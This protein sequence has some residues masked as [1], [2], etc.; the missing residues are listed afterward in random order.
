MIDSARY[1]GIVSAAELSIGL[2]CLA[3]STYKPL[4]K[5]RSRRR[6]TIP[7]FSPRSGIQVHHEISVLRTRHDEFDVE[8]F[9]CVTIYEDE[10]NYQYTLTELP[11]EGRSS[12]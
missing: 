5:L 4:L 6:Q 3:L 8:E 12:S 10:K 2:T 7:E 1:L 11:S 9:A